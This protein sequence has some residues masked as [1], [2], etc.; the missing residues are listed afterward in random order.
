M[1]AC[2]ADYDND[3]FQDVY[4][5]AFGPNVLVRNNGDGTFTDVTAQAGVGDPR[6]STSC[7]FGDYDRDGDRRSLRRQLCGVRASARFRSAAPHRL[8]VHGRRRDVRAEGPRRRAGRPLP[9]QRRR[10]ASPTSRARPASPIRAT[11]ASACCSPISTTTAGPT[12]SSRTIRCRTC[13]SATT[14]TARSR[15]RACV[16]RWRSAATAARRPAWASTPATTT[17]TAA[18]TSFVTNFSQDYN[19]LYQQQR[20]GLLHAM[21]AIRPVSVTPALA[22]LGWGIGFVDFD[23][24]GL[25]DLF[26]ANG[27][28]YPE[29][30]RLGTRHDV[31]SAQAAVPEHRAR[32]VS[33]T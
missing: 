22:Y 7:A 8:Q 14:A 29:I 21:S 4:V 31:P 24:D 5:T 1:G 15:R 12:S 27:H 9:Q 10:H 13:S 2:V 6:W 30:D 20:R 32:A 25:L 33:A 16:R 28:V 26:V 23:N 17:A 11:T 3:G 19:T 18:S